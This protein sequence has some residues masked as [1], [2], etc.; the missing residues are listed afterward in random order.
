MEAH[1]NSSPNRTPRG[2]APTFGLRLPS[3]QHLNSDPLPLTKTRYE[4]RRH[5]LKPAGHWL[6]STTQLSTSCTRKISIRSS[7]NGGGGSVR[8]NVAY[9]TCDCFNCPN[10]RVYEGAPSPP[11]RFCRSEFGDTTFDSGPAWRALW[12]LQRDGD[13]VRILPASLLFDI[14]ELG[15]ADRRSQQFERRFPW[16]L[17]LRVRT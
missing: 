3:G 16:G 1:R 7:T 12:A 13:T 10:R 9:L 17:S 6:R 15:C 4:T 5:N 11:P 8:G 14:A 2:E